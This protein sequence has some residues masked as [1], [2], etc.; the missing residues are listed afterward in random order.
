[1]CL[2]QRLNRRKNRNSSNKEWRSTSTT[3]QANNTPK[4]TLSHKELLEAWQP[5]VYLPPMASAVDYLIEHARAIDGASKTRLDRRT[6]FAGLLLE[7]LSA[8]KTYRCFLEPSASHALQAALLKSKS[9]VEVLMQECSVQ[10]KSD[11]VNLVV[12]RKALIPK[13]KGCPTSRH[14]TRKKCRRTCNLAVERHPHG[15]VSR[16]T[17][18]THPVKMTRKSRDVSTCFWLTPST[19]AEQRESWAPSRRLGLAISFRT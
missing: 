10:S 13:Q 17:T 12:L 16:S 11:R 4:T 8:T 5:S 3:T 9:V 1:M 14:Q 6:L 2:G 15:L 19:P 7:W 18:R